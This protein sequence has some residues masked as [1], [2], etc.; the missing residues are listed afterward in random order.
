MHTHGSVCEPQHGACRARSGL[1]WGAAPLRRPA[2]A[3]ALQQCLN[4]L[5]GDTKP[6]RR[7]LESRFEE[8]KQVAESKHPFFEISVSDWWVARNPGALHVRAGA[9]RSGL[10][11]LDVVRALVC[12]CTNGRLGCERRQLP[13]GSATCSTCRVLQCARRV[14]APSGPPLPSR[15]LQE[16]TWLC[17]EEVRSFPP[18]IH[19]RLRGLMQVVRP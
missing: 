14:R 3:R 6:I 10:H 5:Q 11:G 9:P 2:C 4:L 7:V 15:R 1:F 12:A 13:S 18:Y 8:I 16:M 17:R 19:R